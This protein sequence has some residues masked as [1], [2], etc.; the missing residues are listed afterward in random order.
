[1]TNKK[2]ERASWDETVEE[3]KSGTD[4]F[5]VVGTALL[6]IFGLVGLISLI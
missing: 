4:W 2:V 6:V 1:M 5:M 3:Y